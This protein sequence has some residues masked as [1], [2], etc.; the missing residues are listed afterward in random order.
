[1]AV[2]IILSI[3]LISFFFQPE[4]G[5]FAIFINNETQKNPNAL[6]QQ[7]SF[8]D[9]IL[10]K[11]EELGNNNQD[12]K[13]AKLR[14]IK[15]MAAGNYD[16]AA[17]E[18]EAAIQKYHNAPETLIYLNNAR[19]GAKKAYTIAVAVPIGSDKNGALEI[20]RGVAQ[21]QNE[22]N[23]A[24]GIKAQNE[25]PLKV[26]IANDD[27][28][29]KIAQQIASVLVNNSE[30]LGVVG[31]SSSSATL[32][33]GKE[34]DAGQLVTIS[35]VSTAVQLSGFSPYVFRTV[36]N[37][38]ITARAL[39]NYMLTRLKKQK[40]A[41]FFNSQN[42]YSKSLKSKFVEEVSTNGGQV[43]TDLE[44]DL[45]DPGFSAHKSVKKALGKG[46]QVLML[47]ANTDVLDKA[48]LVI[49][50]NQKRLSLLAG[51]DVYTPKILADGN[52]AAVGMVV[53]VAWHIDGNPG[54]DFRRKSEQLWQ[55]RVNWRTATSY[56]ATQALIAA[57]KSNPTRPG[58]QQVL[59]APNFS[60]TGASSTIKFLSN[61][62][63]NGSIQLVEIRPGK[64]SGTGYDFVPL[65]Y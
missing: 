22:V 40:A 57:L 36:P 34:Y 51:D 2:M 21:A 18:F 39:S 26:V 12:F 60:A 35:A 63:L 55:S 33:A 6:R 59:S 58:V 48:L 19:I 8:G 16:K 14:G 31:H 44:F 4:N 54:S 47:A 45:S 15:Q 62:D 53:A 27:N 41:V 64:T 9:K 7:I 46:A 65:N 17:I 5:L 1:M 56:N 13:T 42:I 61:G 20:L 37:D 3:K 11:E 10:V 32:A 38:A 29:P 52:D 28:E 30:V 25:V 43:D 23:Q 50:A 49:Q 24:G